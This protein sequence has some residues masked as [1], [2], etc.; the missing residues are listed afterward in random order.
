MWC[1]GDAL[2]VFN[3]VLCVCVVCVRVCVCLR[4][5]CVHL[6]SI[7]ACAQ[8]CLRPPNQ[9]NVCNT[10]SFREVPGASCP[11]SVPLVS[12]SVPGPRTLTGHYRD[13]AGHYVTL[14]GHERDTS[15]L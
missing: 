7:G 13:N 6:L 3:F 12:R 15:E 8:F 4:C 10:G 5:V 14:T 2:C 11:V 1:E 9:P